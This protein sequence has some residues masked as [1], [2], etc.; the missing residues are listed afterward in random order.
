M[1]KFVSTYSCCHSSKKL[2][3]TLSEDLLNSSAESKG[4][5]ESLRS[6]KVGLAEPQERFELR[7]QMVT[8]LL[9]SLVDWFFSACHFIF[10]HSLYA[11]HKH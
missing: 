6:G 3:T 8:V 5:V 4:R 10:S 9:S 7:T 1:V 2:L 11:K